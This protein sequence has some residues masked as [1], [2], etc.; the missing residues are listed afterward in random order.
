MD[1]LTLM[2]LPFLECLVLVGIHSYL[3]IH[4]IKRQVIFVDLAIAQIAA[5]GIAV[6]MTF[7]IHP[8]DPGSYIF[9]LLFAL[10]GGTIFSVTRFRRHGVPQEAVIGLVYAL[11]AALSILVMDRS[12][13][14]SEHLKELL[15]GALLW[16]GWPDIIK[17]SIIYAVIGIIHYRF[18]PIF[19]MISSDPERARGK[20]Y[21]L[22]FW[23]LLFYATFAVVIT[24]SV[25][26]AGIL[27]VF[28]FLV[29]PAMMAIS[30]TDRLSIQLLIGWTAGTLVTMAGLL[31]SYFFDLPGSPTVIALY[32][33][34]LLLWSLCV[35]LVRAESR[36]NALKKVVMGL[37]ISVGFLALLFLLGEY[38]H[39]GHAG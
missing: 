17:A 30:V 14:G 38:L 37:M 28:V 5:L 2:A 29:T 34:V 8:G 23:D 35:Y 21:N 33:A 19:Q 39:R 13:L 31:L 16:V 24:T 32:G 18:Q 11:A 25:Q 1:V 6:A 36:I 3:G 7:G 4:V 10:A 27:L 20:G 26:V 12:P 9:S 15:T 22:F